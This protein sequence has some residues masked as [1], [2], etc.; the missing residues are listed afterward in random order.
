MVAAG[1]DLTMYNAALD[2]PF[3][4]SNEKGVTREGGG[5]A[6]RNCHWRRWR[7]RNVGKRLLPQWSPKLHRRYWGPW[8]G[9]PANICLCTIEHFAP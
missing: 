2:I 7:R 5:Y 4:K 3:L 8:G 1:R 6:K 9:S